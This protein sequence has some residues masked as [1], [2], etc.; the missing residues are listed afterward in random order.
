MGAQPDVA[1]RRST[2]A[3]VGAYQPFVNK[4]PN[5]K[6]QRLEVLTSDTLAQPWYWQTISPVTRNRILDQA[7]PKNPSSSNPPSKLTSTSRRYL[8]PHMVTLRVILAHC[9]VRCAGMMMSQS[10][11]DTYRRQATRFAPTYF[12]NKLASKTP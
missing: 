4:N 8:H 7:S 11:D 10:T 12:D 3:A 1:A 5:K 2:A 6:N 9:L